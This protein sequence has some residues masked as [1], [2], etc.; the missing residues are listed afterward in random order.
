MTTVSKKSNIDQIAQA[1][2]NVY[3]E[4]INVSLVGTS[5]GSSQIPIK[6]NKALQERIIINYTATPVD[7]VTPVTLFASFPH[8]VTKVEIFDSSGSIMK[9]NISTFGDM[10][11][12]PGGNGPVDLYCTS[13]T[14]MTI[15]AVDATASSGYFIMNVYYDYY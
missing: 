3:N 6:N 9:I 1:V 5:S 11:V 8:V 14:S 15:V 10:Y 4:S 13:G 12:F 7:T 2:L